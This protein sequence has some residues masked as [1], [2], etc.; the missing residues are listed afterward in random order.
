M[1][2][3]KVENL[4]FTYEG[5]AKPVLNNLSFVLESGSFLTV[6]GVSGCGKSTLL[7]LLKPELAPKGTLSGSISYDGAEITALP[8]G[9]SAAKIGFVFQNPDSQLVTDRV[10]HELAFGPES[11]GMSPELI[12]VRTAEVASYLGICD[13]YERETHTLSG[14]QK[15][16]VNLAS[17]LSMAPELLILDEP[18]AQLDP[19]AREEFIG[20]LSRLHRDTGITIIMAE[21]SLENILPLS[22]RLLIMKKDGTSAFGTVGDS[23]RKLTD[24]APELSAFPASVRLYKDIEKSIGPVSAG[25]VP[26]SISEGRRF[27]TEVVPVTNAQQS[28]TSPVSQFVPAAPAIQ[29]SDVSFS[30][31][32]HGQTVIKD[33]DTVIYS[34][35]IFTLLGG[36]G[37]GKSTLMQL[38]AGL[39]RPDSGRIRIFGRDIRKY[40]EAELYNILSML[41]QQVETMFIH[42]T[43]EEELKNIPEPVFPI[44]VP[45]STHPYDLSG[46]EKALLAM[47]VALSRDIKLLLLDE[48]TKGLDAENRR[49]VAAALRQ[50]RARGITVLL[51]THDTELAAVISDRV[52]MLFDGRIASAGTPHAFFGSNFY[53]TTAFARMTRGLY[54]GIITEEEC[55]NAILRS[56]GSST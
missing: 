48:P 9:D 10:W 13:L 49:R 34:G 54:E 5:C 3:I 2:K 56:Q 22:D 4:T 19:I 23:L 36:N 55:V 46:G 21:H 14:G 27:I 38:A 39:L 31:D 53:Y 50:L 30:Y 7:S 8:P 40:T 45:L 12:R 17:V 24:T 41:P 33:L 37:Q 44:D 15:Q 28:G 16:L 18:T 43:V 6:T 52:G 25:T 1:E 35:E 32:R 47:D 26:V 11:L 20:I 42:D 29:F 51:I